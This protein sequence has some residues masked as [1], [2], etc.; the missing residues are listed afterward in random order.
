M[1][2]YTFPN[3]I[4]RKDYPFPIVYFQHFCQKVVDLICLGL[5][6]ESE[7]SQLCPTLWDPIDCS[8]PGS[9]VHRIFQAIVLE[10]IAISF[11]RA[12]SQPRTRTWVSR[13]VDRRFTVWATREVLGLFGGSLLCSVDL[14]VCFYANTICYF[15]YYSFV[16]EFEIE[17]W[18]LK[19]CFSCSKVL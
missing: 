18:C 9:S 19:P 16:I 14:H 10:W 7:L 1:W 12:S 4:Y 6:S 11:S 3:T 2:L 5:F 17:V 15:D 13:I 8:L